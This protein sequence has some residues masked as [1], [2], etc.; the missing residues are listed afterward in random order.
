MPTVNRTSGAS[1]W[2]DLQKTTSSKNK[3]TFSPMFE[4]NNTNVNNDTFNKQDKR[5]NLEQQEQEWIKNFIGSRHTFTVYQNTEDGYE[6]IKITLI[7]I[8]NNR[9]IMSQDRFGLGK[10]VCYYEIENETGKIMY[11]Q[12]RTGNDIFPRRVYDKDGS[13]HEDKISLEDMM[14]ETPLDTEGVDFNKE[15]QNGPAH[16]HW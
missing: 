1:L 5:P 13:V 8:D 10:E 2:A 6:E 12:S 11:K 7:K 16:I 15:P 3:S 4:Y 9:T 14:K